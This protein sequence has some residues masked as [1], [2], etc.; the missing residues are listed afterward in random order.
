MLPTAENWNCPYKNART[1]FRV[2][3]RAHNARRPILP[4][5]NT[6]TEQLLQYVNTYCALVGSHRTNMSALYFNLFL[7]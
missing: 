3:I 6:N 5:E 2:E 4:T 1:V 7:R